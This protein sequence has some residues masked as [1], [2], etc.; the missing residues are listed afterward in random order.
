MTAS[1]NQGGIAVEKMLILIVVIVLIVF[2]V[3]FAS[4]NSGPGKIEQ[5]HAAC[6]Q[7]QPPVKVDQLKEMFGQ[8]YPSAN[9]HM[10]RFNNVRYSVKYTDEIHGTTNQETGEVTELWCSDKE[11]VW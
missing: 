10:F 5:M 11:R 2:G 7:L 3:R 4:E 9:P 1:L 6:L 8:V